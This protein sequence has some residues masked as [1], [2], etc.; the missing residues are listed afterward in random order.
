MASSISRWLASGSCQPV[1]EAVDDADAA[2]GV[3][4]QV[5]PAAAGVDHARLV[6]HGLERAHDGRAD[7]DHPAARAR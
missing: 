2:P 3:I 5:R 6:G 1:S 4:D 7:G